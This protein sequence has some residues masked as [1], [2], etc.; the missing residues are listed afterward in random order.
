MATTVTSTRPL[1]GPALVAVQ[2]L[3]VRTVTVRASETA[4]TSSFPA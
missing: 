1:K 3:V 2:G 4:T